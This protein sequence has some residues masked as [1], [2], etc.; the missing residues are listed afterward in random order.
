MATILLVDES[1]VNLRVMQYVLSREGHKVFLAESGLE[2]LYCLQDNRIDLI[3]T[4]AHM[5]LMDGFE[6]VQHIRNNPKYLRLPVLMLTNVGDEDVVRRARRSSVNGFLTQPLNSRQL[7][8]I[9]ARTLVN[10]LQTRPLG[11]KILPNY[12]LSNLTYS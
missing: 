1:R 7:G 8:E 2:G 9:V 3:I 10:R 11:T 6:F 4:E 12:G 5:Q